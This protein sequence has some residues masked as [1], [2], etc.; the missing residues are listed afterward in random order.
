[1]MKSK[2][3]VLQSVQHILQL[4][5][6]EFPMLK[7]M[8]GQHGA[9]RLKTGVFQV[10]FAQADS[11]VNTTEFFHFLSTKLTGEVLKCAV[12]SGTFPSFLT[13][14]D[15]TK[16]EFILSRGKNKGERFESDLLKAMQSFLRGEKNL[17]LASDAIAALAEIDERLKIDNL[18]EAFAREGKVNRK[19]VPLEQTGSI[20]G[21]I[22]LRDKSGAR[23][24]ISVKNRTGGTIGSLGIA[25]AFTGLKINRDTEDWSMCSVFGLDADKFEQ[26][27]ENYVKKCDDTFDSVQ[28]VDINVDGSVLEFMLRLWGINYYYLR[29]KKNGF[30]A[31]YISKENLLERE[32]KNLRI[33]RYRY[34]SGEGRGRKSANVMLESDYMS[35]KVE[36]RDSKKGI[37]PTQIQLSVA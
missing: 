31:R 15:G 25:K 1:M 21:D 12:N 17:K 33:K 9:D 18:I 13:E 4:I 37:R 3:D 30:F 36:V 22:I 14:V 8:V 34:P 10:R 7:E 26:G 29:E 24:Y 5:K 11:D 19:T 32:L 28:E 23:Y 6:S 35:Y 2:R 20:I 16:V 27:L